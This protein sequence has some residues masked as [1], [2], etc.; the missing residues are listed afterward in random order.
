[1]IILLIASVLLWGRR[2]GQ[3][4]WLIAMMV[5][6]AEFLVEILVVCSFFGLVQ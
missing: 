2:I 3:D 5:G 4:V 6:L 1:M